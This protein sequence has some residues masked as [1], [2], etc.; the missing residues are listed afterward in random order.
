MQTRNRDIVFTSTEDIQKIYT[1]GKVLGVGSF[2][3]VV[4]AKMNKNPE[5]Q[6]AI[7]IIEKVKV[8]GREDILANEIYIL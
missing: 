1:F 3:K 5:K 6:F 8:K 7:K 4:T 2:G